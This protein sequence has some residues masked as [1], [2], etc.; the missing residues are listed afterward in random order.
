MGGAFGVTL[1]SSKPGPLMPP[2]TKQPQGSPGLGAGCNQECL[3][4]SVLSPLAGCHLLHPTLGAPS[5]FS[6]PSVCV[7]PG[8]KFR[9]CGISCCG[10]G[11]IRLLCKRP[12]HP[13]PAHCGVGTGG[14]C[15]RQGPWLADPA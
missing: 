11:L 12:P 2:G 13:A 7:L 1:G 8:C 9:V 4:W 6:F 5:D 10:L 15:H 14:R 3:G